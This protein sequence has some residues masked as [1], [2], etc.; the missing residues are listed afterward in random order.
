[1]TAQFNAAAYLVDRHLQAGDGGRTAVR[2]EGSE[3]S[4]RQ[5]ADLSARIAAGLR[6]L[7]VR[8]EERVL[9]LM[10]DGPELLAAILGCFRAGIVAVP[11]STMLTGRDLG[12][13]LA[14]SGARTLIA[15]SEFAE[16]AAEAV[17]HAP[18]VGHLVVVGPA[19]PALRRDVVRVSWAEL[20][21]S[22]D[23]YDVPFA[24]TVEDSPALW[25][26]TSGTTGSPKAAMHRHANIRHV[27]QTYAAQVLGIRP[28]DRCLSVA[29]LFFAYGLGNSALFPLCVGATTI[30][31]P[32]RPTPQTIA[33]RIR[34]DAPT[35]LFGV[36]SFFAAMLAADLPADL[37]SGVR[38]V[39][40]AGEALPAGLHA[41]FTERFGRPILD[42]LGST[43]ALHI[44]LSNAPGDIGLGTSGRPVPGYDVEIRDENGHPVPPGTP[45]SLFVRGESI[46]TGYWCRTAAT[47][48][49]FQGEWLATGDT[50]LQQPDGRY[51]CL[52]RSSDL[53]KA[54]GLWVTP[55]EVEARLLEHPGVV[56]AAVVGVPDADGLDKPVA[57]VVAHPRVPA[58]ADELVAFCRDGLAHFKVPR[59]VEF[60]DGLPRTATGK[61]QRYKLRD[62]ALSKT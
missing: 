40:S 32:R 45:G 60:V 55:S 2:C 50:Y 15:T 62:A 33:E 14:D 54:G 43:E 57:Y 30:L 39:A 42:G 44:F 10:A 25:L 35:L 47:R 5:L 61:L 31:D 24:S 18:E 51:A 7:G 29:K 27:C 26:Y 12:E 36:P 21:D 56:D 9:F 28:D 38:L 34:R 1:M 23:P 3:L 48:A 52:G 17:R 16:T 41:R 6:R 58:T 46:A 37:L 22:A 8:R 53:F 11:A 13:I 19:E 20:V 4:Y 49:V 59:R